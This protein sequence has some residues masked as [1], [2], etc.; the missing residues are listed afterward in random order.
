MLVASSCKLHHEVVQICSYR[1][2]INLGRPRTF[3]S[4]DVNLPRISEGIAEVGYQKLICYSV[5]LLTT[6]DGRLRLCSDF[7]SLS[8]CRASGLL[9]A[10]II[11]AECSVSPN[12]LLN[13]SSERSRQLSTERSLALWISFQ[14]VHSRMYSLTSQFHLTTNHRIDYNIRSG[15]DPTS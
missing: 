13:P 10:N 6:V 14:D 2:K 12:S 1:N 5:L 3:V 15:A 11:P 7:A 9:K 4:A 8:S